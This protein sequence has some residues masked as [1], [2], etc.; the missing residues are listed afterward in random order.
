MLIYSPFI[1]N[2]LEYTLEHILGINLGIE[3]SI[4]DDLERFREFSGQKLAYSKE[5][6]DGSPWI[7]AEGLLSSDKIDRQLTN[8][9]NGKK[10]KGLP[11]IFQAPDDSS[12]PFDIF[13][14]VFYFLSRYEE[15][16]PFK[17][18]NH[19]RFPSKEGIPYRLGVLD[20]PIA[21]LWMNSF[22]EYLENTFGENIKIK[23]HQF[24][25]ESTIDIDNAWAFRHKGFFRTLGAIFRGGQKM[26]TRNFRYQVLMGNQEDP[27]FQYPKMDMIHDEYGIKPK[28]FFLVGPYGR[29]DRNV[30]PGNNAFRELVY[31][32]AAHNDTGLHPSYASLSNPIKI[33]KEKKILEEITGRDVLSSRQH[34][35]RMQLPSTYRSLTQAGIKN[36]YTMG[37]ADSSGFRAGT[38]RPFRF[39]D[40]DSNKA[41][42]LTVYPFQ[43]MDTG[44]RYYEKLGPG[45]AVQ[46]I[47]GLMDITREAGGTF[48][49]LWHNESFSEWAGWEGWTDVYLKMLEMAN[50]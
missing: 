46:K 36:D 18:D 6:A 40:L 8:I 3:F 31:Q 17:A 10:W 48:R 42:K 5:R 22:G 47:S 28:Y 41:T 50:R 16:L 26:E 43:V 14:S 44:L 24:E 21:D 25:F 35:L 38:C 9:D 19:G 27:Y 37:F 39:F 15:Y 12:I 30:R 7:W 11:V 23:K 20:K 34:Y 32:I 1:S 2:R 29:Y 49:C 13:S 45:E 33:S 4:T